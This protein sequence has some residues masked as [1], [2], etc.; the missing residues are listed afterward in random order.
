[1]KMVCGVP[2]LCDQRSIKEL[3]S[4][5]LNDKYITGNVKNIIMKDR[6]LTWFY[7]MMTLD[8]LEIHYKISYDTIYSC[9]I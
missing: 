7:D 2:F 6:K 3:H 5:N 8:M 1:M 9:K 4:S